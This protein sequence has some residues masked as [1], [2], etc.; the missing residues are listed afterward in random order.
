M[1][2][3]FQIQLHVYFAES[4][5]THAQVVCLKTNFQFQITIIMWI[6]ISDLNVRKDNGQNSMPTAHFLQI[7]TSQYDC[8]QSYCDILICMVQRSTVWT[9]KPSSHG[10]GWKIG[11]LCV[12][13]FCV[14]KAKTFFPIF[15]FSSMAYGSQGPV[16]SCARRR[17]AQI[18]TGEKYR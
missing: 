17:L 9:A 8:M 16:S 6:Q 1:T 18:H 10:A 11:T 14:E 15:Q 4:T 5:P 2:T 7:R 13:L 3:K 12:W